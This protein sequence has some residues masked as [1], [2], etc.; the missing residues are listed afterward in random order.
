MV[1]ARTASK[2][3]R[4]LYMWIGSAHD[5]KELKHNNTYFDKM[6]NFSYEDGTVRVRIRKGKET[7]RFLSL[8]D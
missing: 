6:T 7:K 2:S 3:N 1:D 5:F 8:F 4:Y